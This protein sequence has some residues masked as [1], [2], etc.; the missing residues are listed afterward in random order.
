MSARAIGLRQ[1][2][3]GFQVEWQGA[4]AGVELAVVGAHQVA[5]ALAA[6]AVGLTLGLDLEVV[7]AALSG[8]TAR[9]KWRMEI[10]HRPDGVTIVNDSYNASPES[11]R[12]ALRALVALS[13]DAS[14]RTWAVL[15]NMAEL[16]DRAAEIHDEVGRLAVELDVSQLVVIGERASGIHAGAMTARPGG[17]GVSAVTS[18]EDAF[19][20]LSSRLEPGD[21]VLVKGSRA[22]GLD[23]LAALL[24]GEVQ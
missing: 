22:A 17:E 8:A 5:N 4:S 6:A 11:M 12:A 19:A 2:K 1:G 7:A 15:G 13:G 21:V 10:H 16:G 9:S 14:R 23:R 3:A 20:L 18:L 24:C